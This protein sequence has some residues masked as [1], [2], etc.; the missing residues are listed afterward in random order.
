MPLTACWTT[1]CRARCAYYLCPKH[2]CPSYRK[3]V[4]RELLEGQFES[5][6][7]ELQPSENLFCARSNNCSTAMLR[8]MSLPSSVRTRSASVKL[9]E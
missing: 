7:R 9:E 5:L 2:G 6:L 1:G 8:P 4:R 3:S